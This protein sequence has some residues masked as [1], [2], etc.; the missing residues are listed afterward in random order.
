ML[1]YYCLVLLLVVIHLIPLIMF[2]H[3]LTSLPCLLQASSSVCMGICTHVYIGERSCR[4]Y[5]MFSGVAAKMKTRYD[6]R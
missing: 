6:D 3:Q 5:F 4:L 2:L 1:S